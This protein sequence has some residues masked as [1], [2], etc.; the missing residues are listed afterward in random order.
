[1]IDYPDM[2]RKAGIQGR[3]YHQFEVTK[4]GEVE[5]PTV[6]RGPGAGLNKEALRVIRK[7][8]LRLGIQQ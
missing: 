4:Q 5:N 2:A 6:T 8:E 3:V 1:M 7:A